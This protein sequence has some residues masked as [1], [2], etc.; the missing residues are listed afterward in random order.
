MDFAQFLK[1][2]YLQPCKYCDKYICHFCADRVWSS[3]L[4]AQ[5]H[6]RADVDVALLLPTQGAELLFIRTTR[7][8]YPLQGSPIPNLLGLEFVVDNLSSKTLRKR[9]K[10][11]KYTRPMFYL[12]FLENNL[13]YHQ[14]PSAQLCLF[15]AV[16][17]IR[18]TLKRGPIKYLSNSFGFYINEVFFELWAHQIK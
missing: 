18:F 10:D 9:K 4:R 14:C 11:T 15:R 12:S 5:I 16:P 17:Q 8:F 7:C 13:N 1:N 6:C 2:C 3:E